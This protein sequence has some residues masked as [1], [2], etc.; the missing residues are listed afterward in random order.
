MSKYP[1]HRQTELPTNPTNYNW[2]PVPHPT[3]DIYVVR[4]NR[5]YYVRFGINGWVITSHNGYWAHDGERWVCSRLAC[6][7]GYVGAVTR[8]QAVKFAESLINKDEV[9]R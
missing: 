9:R 7:K 1:W 4:G 5:R 8:E 2:M 3:G 6:P